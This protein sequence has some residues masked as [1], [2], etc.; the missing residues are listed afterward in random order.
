MP[1]TSTTNPGGNNDHSIPCPH[2]QRRRIGPLA[3]GLSDV[4]QE[5]RNGI[6]VIRTP[7]TA[8]DSPFRILVTFLIEAELFA[9]HQEIGFKLFFESSAVNQNI[10]FGHAVRPDGFKPQVRPLRKFIEMVRDLAVIGPRPAFA[11]PTA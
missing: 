4:E 2:V 5:W 6:E 10:S 9:S 8:A 1:I 7:L 3:L 11:V